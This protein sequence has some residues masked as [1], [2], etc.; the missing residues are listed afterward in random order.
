MNLRPPG[1]E[2]DELPDCSTPRE[3]EHL[4]TVLWSLTCDPCRALGEVFHEPSA[5]ARRRYLPPLPQKSPL[6]FDFRGPLINGWRW[7]RTTE[8]VDN[9]FT[10]CP[11][12]P[13][14]KPP[15][16]T[17]TPLLFGLRKLSPHGAPSRLLSPKN[18][19]FASI[20]GDPFQPMIGLEPITC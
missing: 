10:V 17:P 19:R 1:Y 18:L 3:Y 8:V 6:R 2:P 14:G 4:A 20:F 7:I 9:R 5:T 15:S 12:W 16:S 13:L 11:L